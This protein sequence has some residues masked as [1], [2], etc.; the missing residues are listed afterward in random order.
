[1]TQ[2]IDRVMRDNKALI[3]A[4]D[5]GMEHGPIDFNEE[6]VDPNYILEIALQGRYSAVVVGKGIAAH[7]Y[8]T[9]K[10]Y[11]QKIPL[12]L[13]LNGKTRFH[14][15]DPFSPLNCTVE[16]A[17]YLGAVAVGYTVYVGSPREHLMIR[18]FGEVVREAR[19][20]RLATIGWMY[21]RGHLIK[22]ETPEITAYAARIGM[23]L[24][25]DMVKVKYTGDRSTLSWVVKSA[26]RTKVVVSGGVKKDKSKFL[27]EVQSVM[28]AGAAGIAVGRNVW[29]SED[30]M[31]VTTELKNIVYTS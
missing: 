28:H 31:G 15:D 13:K 6:S 8:Q 10:H 18:E 25:A 22:E 11:Y 30:P 3:L 21:P 19:K 12:I 2:L 9:N 23:E 1:M 27:E 14:R 24:G 4:Y 5:Q 7:Y 26:G 17:A 29:Q 20:Y 16:E